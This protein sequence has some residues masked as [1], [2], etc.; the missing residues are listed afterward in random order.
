M[1]YNYHAEEQAIYTKQGTIDLLKVEK[2][3]TEVLGK[4]GAIDMGHAM[5]ALSSGCSWYMMALVDHLCIN[6]LIREVDHGECAGQH[7]IFVAGRG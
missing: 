3:I 6:G 7:R 2:H 1:S 4:S 5:N